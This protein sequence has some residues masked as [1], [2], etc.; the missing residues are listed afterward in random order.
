MV[1]FAD[2]AR[3]NILLKR[4]R[5]GER[6]EGERREEGEG[7]EEEEEEREREREREIHEQQMIE[8]C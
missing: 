7:E 6:G 4:E 3:F 1:D 5:N 2:E 8:W